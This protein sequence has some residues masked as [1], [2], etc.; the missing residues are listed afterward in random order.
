MCS[1]P[2]R[3]HRTHTR[4]HACFPRVR[5]SASGSYS[6]LYWS[7]NSASLAAASAHSGRDWSRACPA[8]AFSHFSRASCIRICTCG[9]FVVVPLW[10]CRRIDI[11]YEQHLSRPPHAVFLDVAPRRRPTVP[12]PPL[13]PIRDTW[14]SPR[15]GPA[16]SSHVHLF[17]HP[18]LLLPL[19]VQRLPVLASVLVPPLSRLLST[20]RPGLAIRL[21]TLYDSRR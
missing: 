2:P 12:P 14:L 6:W 3:S 17:L 5:A 18:P 21:L 4:A 10:L 11:Q 16:S 20:H 8:P 1:R 9:R 15:D 19:T 13:H 7:S